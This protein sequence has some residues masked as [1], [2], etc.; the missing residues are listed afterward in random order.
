MIKHCSV[1]ANLQSAGI[2]VN[3]I[4]NLWKNVE[5]AIRDVY[6]GESSAKL[7]YSYMLSGNYV[8]EYSGSKITTTE[9][10]TAELGEDQIFKEFA[11]GFLA[12]CRVFEQ[13]FS[14]TYSPFTFK[15]DIVPRA[16]HDARERGVSFPSD[17][18]EN[19]VSLLSPEALAEGIGD[20]RIA[21]VPVDNEG[22]T[23]AYA[24]IPSTHP[25]V[26]SD[27]GG[28]SRFDKDERWRLD[29]QTKEGYISLKYVAI[30]EFLHNFGLGH[31]TSANSILRP[32][33]D[34]SQSVNT[35]FPGG[36]RDSEEFF[37]LHKAYAGN[38]FIVGLNKQKIYR[39]SGVTK[40]DAVVT[41]AHK[42]KGSLK[43]ISISPAGYVY[44]TNSKHNVYIRKGVSDDKP[45]GSGFKRI[46]GSLRQISAGAMIIGVNKKNTPYIRS[47]ISEDNPAG[48]RWDKMAN[49]KMNAVV[50]SPAACDGK[51]AIYGLYQ[52]KPYFRHQVT[53]DN[54]R[55]THWSQI[56]GWNLKEIVVGCFGLLVFALNLAG[57]VYRRTQISSLNLSGTAWKKLSYTKRFA[58]ISISP[59][60][61]LYAID[62]NGVLYYRIGITTKSLD[63]K[64]W[65]RIGNL[66]K[67]D[68][69]S[70]GFR[71]P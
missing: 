71:K 8:R 69:L 3:I 14:K 25:N 35:L 57:Q 51:I 19:P 62:A 49:Q 16:G 39:L 70:I 41:N 32:S 59:T 40:N 20:L 6:K 15:L 9:F 42:W 30:H 31:D 63:G 23:L 28:D 37:T 17:Y 66:D 2:K 24:Y 4:G 13:L 50:C 61:D 7:W 5:K 54:P 12:I 53:F 34:S 26:Y 46:S 47:G 29:S 55:G 65:R 11:D 27:I 68:T 52:R 1:A 44:G 60:G 33:V 22:F 21:M 67:L 45:Y 18:F 56:S 10:K 38:P 58:S 43:S 64:K 48:D 36:L